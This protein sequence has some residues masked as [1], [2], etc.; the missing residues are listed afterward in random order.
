MPNALRSVCLILGLGAFILHAQQYDL[1]VFSLGDGL[2]GASVH[3]FQEDPDGF[4]WM[5]TSAGICRTDGRHF[6]TYDRR[7]GLRDDEVTAILRDPAGRLWMGSRRGLMRW[8]QGRFVDAGPGALREA[9]ITGLT[10]DHLGHLWVSSRSLGTWRALDP[11]GDTWEVVPQL[12]GRRVNATAARGRSI[13]FA[14]D[15][16]VVSWQDDKAIVWPIGGD[17]EA[18]ALFA[19]S[20]C[21]LVGSRQGAWVVTDTGSHRLDTTNVLPTNRVQSL[22]R[23]RYGA[24]WIGTPM[25]LVM[26]ER[27]LNDLSNARTLTTRNGLGNNDVRALYQD[28]SG[29]VWIGT[30]YGGASKFV[31]LA[32]IHF[33]D[34]DGLGSHIVSAVQRTRDG[35]VW[36]GTYGGGVAHFDGEALTRYGPG[37][38]LVDPFVLSLTCDSSGRVIAGTAHEG[39]FLLR[40]GR[41]VN[42]GTPRPTDRR[43][44]FLTT[45]GEGRIWAGTGDGLVCA[46]G[47]GGVV[48]MP[49]AAPVNAVA[50][51]GDTVWI[52]TSS[53]LYVLDTRRLPWAPIRMPLVPAHSFTSL[54]RDAMGNLWCGSEGHG[55]FRLTGTRL[56]SL[57]RQGGM[58]SAQGLGNGYVEQVLLDA[59]QNLWIGTRY[60][61]D[62]VMLDELQ[63][64]VIDIDHYGAEEGFIGMETFRN[65]CLLDPVDSALWFGTVQGLTR[66]QPDYLLTDPNEPSTRLTGLELFYEEVDW[67]PW[68]EQVDP[69]GLPRGLVLPYNKNQ[70]TFSFVGVSLAYP[71][72]VRYQYFLEGYD[73]DWSP[74]TGQDRVTY[75]N[76]QPGEY[77]FQVIARNASGVWNQEPFRFRFSVEPPVWRT[78][79]FQAAAALACVLL[80]L[81]FVRSRT[82]RLRRDRERLEGMVRVRTSELA[83]EKQRSEQLLLNI[84]PESTALELR[85]HGRA[86]ARSY[87]SC[88][89]LFSDF[90]GF[91]R[92]SAQLGDTRLVNDLDRFFRAFD[93][94]TDRFGVEKIKTIGDAYMCAAGLPEPKDRHALATVLMALAMLDEVDRVNQERSGEGLSEWPIRIGVHTGPVIA[95]VVG[96]KKFA[97]DVWGDTV[98]LASRMESNG[99]PGRVNISG[100]T[101][102]GVMEFVQCTPR[103]PLQVKNKGEMQMYFLDRLRPEYSA[104]HAGRVPNERLLALLS[105]QAT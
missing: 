28:R 49:L 18:T 89:V 98:N 57:T 73:P 62:H 85:E 66:Y 61:L 40:D 44:N 81:G 52:A 101:Y 25:G 33:T 11:V 22:L 69:Q 23:G 95:G 15:K 86:E 19:D 41:F 97:Y 39:A 38:G 36:I 79:G 31:S 37:K 56:D 70:L 54:V 67:S 91:T 60:G 93:R 4:L 13:L 103:G 74:I 63:E 50:P 94:L 100:A 83:E 77:T 27:G 6:R 87:R 71:E 9:E 20:T 29:A 92:F 51:A 14:T 76:L 75:S 84:L 46:P 58:G 3:A 32:F 48:R 72:K 8:D 2:P 7:A 88:T 30:E 5:G 64:N 65:A 42:M 12:A 26:L 99:A 104:D 16:G 105:A 17:V 21:T 90:Q 78:T 10:I 35:D 1:R 53:G 45:D 68:C 34:R 80:V 96:E 55:L 102:A 59:V 47:D 24:I 82:R 43:T